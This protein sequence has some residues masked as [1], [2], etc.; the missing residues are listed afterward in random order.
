MKRTRNVRTQAWK[1]AP[2]PSVGAIMT[3]KVATVEPQQAASVAWSR[4]RRQKVRHLV[5]MESGQLRGILSE[6]DLGGRSGLRDRTGRMVE[7][8]M[9]PRVVSATPDTSL[10]KAANL[11]GKQRIGSLPIVEDGRLVGIVTATEVFDELE[12]RSSRG[13]FPGW[14]PRPAK[15][16]SGRA[17][18]PSIPAHIRLLGAELSREDRARLREKMGARLGKFADS[19]ERITVRVKDVNG[20]RG[21]IDQM[22]QIKVVLIGLPSV[23]FEAQDALLDRAINKALAGAERSVRQNLQRRRMEPM[24]RQARTRPV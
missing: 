10:E 4:M 22:C 9:T 6:G 23:V 8:V 7:D 16:E 17:A 5:V 24:K 14:L 18:L 2:E 19:I 3:T 1:D 13:A 20:P 11:I 15:V 21:G 12:R